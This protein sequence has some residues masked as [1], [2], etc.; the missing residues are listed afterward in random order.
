MA[1]LRFVEF[2]NEG[3][4][5]ARQPVGLFA[6]RSSAQR[7]SGLS[8]VIHTLHGKEVSGAPAHLPCDTMMAELSISYRILALVLSAHIVPVEILP[9]TIVTLLTLSAP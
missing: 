6:T 9:R 8:M 4:S 3:D 2:G 5:A 1:F 7:L